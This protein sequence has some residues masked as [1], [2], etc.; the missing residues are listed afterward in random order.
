MP[1]ATR[2]RAPIGERIVRDDGAFAQ[3]PFM[4]CLH[5]LEEWLPGWPRGRRRWAATGRAVTARL[6]RGYRQA[7]PGEAKISRVMAFDCAT[8][9]IMPAS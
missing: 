3:T 1:I 9:A 7:V 4:H 2:I 8:G 6:R 5:E